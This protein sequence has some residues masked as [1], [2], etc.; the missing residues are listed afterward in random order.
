MTQTSSMDYSIDISRTLTSLILGLK[1]G[2]YMHM[3]LYNNNHLYICMTMLTSFN[4]ID[5]ILCMIQFSPKHKQAVSI[6]IYKHSL[7]IIMLF[8]SVSP[9]LNL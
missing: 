4:F 5:Q 6:A 8:I 1:Q 7:H 2:L 9:Y 3:W